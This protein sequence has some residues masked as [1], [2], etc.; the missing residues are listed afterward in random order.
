MKFKPV[1]P[2]AFILMSITASA[3]NDP[4]ESPKL[5]EV[6]SFD[7]YQPIGVAVTKTGRTFVTFPRNKI[8]EYAVAEITGGQKKPYP[9]AEWNRYDSTKAETHFVNAQA[10]WPDEEDNLWILDPANP[11]DEATIPAGVK[12]LKINL[13]TNKVERVYRFEDLPREKIALNDVRVDTRRQLAYLS[14]PKTASIIILDLKTGKSRM[15]L[16]E[17]KSTKAT[18]GFKLHIDG[19]DVIDQTGKPFSSNVNGI[20][21]TKDGKYFYYRAINQTKLY[22][23][24]VQDLVN[25]DLSDAQLSAKVETV[26]ETGISHGMIADAKGN[27]YSSDSPNKAIRYITADGKFETLVKDKRLIWPDT[28]SVGNDGYLYVTCSQINRT[29]KYNEGQDKVEY[30]FRLYKIKLP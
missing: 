17:D 20:A 21:L 30:P 25:P 26:G 11:M 29:K 27:I 9:D 6:A 13:N 10:A 24:L 7:H 14:E 28:F 4:P 5:I 1:L 19:K 16:K 8:Y 23:I 2:I 3:Q 12:L 15:V 18:P 22:R